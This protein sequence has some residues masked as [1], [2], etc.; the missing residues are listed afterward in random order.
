MQNGPE[1]LLAEIF[2]ALE[3]KN[4]RGDIEPLR[5]LACMEH[6]RLALHPGDMRIEPVLRLGIDH[7]ADMGLRAGGITEAEFLRGTD[8]HLDH[9]IRYILLHAKQAQ[10]RTALACRAEGREHHVIRHLFRQGRGIHDHRVDAARF[11]D[12]RDDRAILR[13]E[14]AIDAACR[15][16]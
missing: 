2:D 4:M 6:L 9:A 1:D 12:Q 11:R 10:G 7:R 15:F 16:C 5:G 8:D 13:G 14:R 3:S